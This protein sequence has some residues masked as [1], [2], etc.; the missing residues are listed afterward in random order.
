MDVMVVGNGFDIAHGLPTRYSDFLYVVSRIIKEHNL[1]PGR[2][3]YQ[4]V[5]SFRLDDMDKVM[6]LID[7]ESGCHNEADLMM[8]EMQDDIRQLIDKHKDVIN[9]NDWLRYFIWI[10]AGLA[11]IKEFDSWI[12]FETELG[13]CLVKLYSKINK[14]FLQGNAVIDVKCFDY[15]TRCY[16]TE[17]FPF[18]FSSKVVA[19]PCWDRTYLLEWTYDCLFQQLLDLSE[20][21]RDYLR[22]VEKFYSF[23][24]IASRRKFPWFCS[25]NTELEIAVSF[26]Y[27]NI[28]ADYVGPGFVMYV[29]GELSDGDDERLI[30]GI[31]ENS[32]CSEDPAIRKYIHRF[33]KSEQRVECDYHYVYFEAFKTIGVDLKENIVLHIVEHSLHMNDAKVIRS[34]LKH[35]CV[36]K[37]I[38][39]YYSGSDK[40]EKIARLND[41][42]GDKDFFECVN[43]TIEKPFIEL[44]HTDSLV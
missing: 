21:L 17:H 9:K 39:Y 5:E 22:I 35:P 44:V 15:E 37:V 34:I 11:N 18:V 42:L 43:N 40:R 8:D 16:K 2:S 41:L 14:P 3:W 31:E 29:N 33:F 7:K 12:D 28:I 32:I 24:P 13:D 4:F 1:Y 30:L 26:N 36:D 19:E 38:V 10:Y 23:K 20:L 25:D 6:A 27:T